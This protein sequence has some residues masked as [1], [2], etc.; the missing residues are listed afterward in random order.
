MAKIFL[1]LAVSWFFLAVYSKTIPIDRKVTVEE[2]IQIELV[3]TETY[4]QEFKPCEKD[5][6]KSCLPKQF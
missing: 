3:A 6:Y 4:L 5:L 2:V 1:T